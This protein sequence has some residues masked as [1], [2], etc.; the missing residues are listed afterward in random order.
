MADVWDIADAEYAAR[1]DARIIE[2]AL[3]HEWRGSFWCHCGYP[4][5]SNSGYALHLLRRA[6]APGDEDEDDE[7]AT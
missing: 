3:A 6:L 2:L 7:T 4:I 1:V 5:A